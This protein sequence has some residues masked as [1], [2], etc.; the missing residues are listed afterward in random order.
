MYGDTEI[1]RFVPLGHKLPIDLLNRIDEE[2][3]QREN[4]YYGIIATGLIIAVHE[5]GV[6]HRL[7][8]R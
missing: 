1:E 4:V 6:P 7:D 8:H 5:D 3:S 2:N